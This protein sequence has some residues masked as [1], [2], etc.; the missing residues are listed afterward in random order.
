MVVGQ[1]NLIDARI[2][3]WRRMLHSILAQSKDIASG[4]RKLNARDREWRRGRSHGEDGTH[5]MAMLA[6]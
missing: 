4:T 6:S 5:R 2:V 3:S 1:K